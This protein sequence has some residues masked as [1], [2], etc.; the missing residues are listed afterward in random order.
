MLI[1]RFVS[2]KP[3]MAD[4]ALRGAAGDVCREPARDV[5]SSSFLWILKPWSFHRSPG[6]TA[7]THHKR[8]RVEDDVCFRLQLVTSAKN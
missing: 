2:H 5:L 8:L 4:G 7:S 3:P 1:A 6:D